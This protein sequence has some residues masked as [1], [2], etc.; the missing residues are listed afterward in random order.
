MTKMN[1]ES[2]EYQKVNE[3]NSGRIAIWFLLFGLVLFV[4]TTSGCGGSGNE[5]NLLHPDVQYMADTMFSKRK[6]NL[7]K[8]QDTL[9]ML[10]AEGLI[11][12]LVDSLVALEEESIKQ[13]SGR[14]E[15]LD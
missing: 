11:A 15:L 4:G 2:L 6:R 8:K 9:C 3:L 5:T 13:I 7:I 1:L 10:K 12:H 14:E